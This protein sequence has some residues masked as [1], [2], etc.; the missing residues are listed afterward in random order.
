[1]LTCFQLVY[2]CFDFLTANETQL[3]NSSHKPEFKSP[4]EERLIRKMAKMALNGYEIGIQRKIKPA[5][6]IQSM[7]EKIQDTVVTKHPLNSDSISSGES[8]RE[9]TLRRPLP[10]NFERGYN[11]MD[12]IQSIGDKIKDTIMSKHP[13]S[14]NFTNG[15]SSMPPPPPLPTS[16]I[17]TF[18]VHSTPIVTTSVNTNTKKQTDT[19]K[20]LNHNFGPESQIQLT[21]NKEKPY[22]SSG[23][24]SSDDSNKEKSDDSYTNTFQKK[25]GLEKAFLVGMNTNS[26]Q[27]YKPDKT[28]DTNY[29]NTLSKRNIFEKMEANNGSN[30]NI[31]KINKTHDFRN[32]ILSETN[33]L[34]KPSMFEKATKTE[35]GKNITN[36]EE[37][38]NKQILPNNLHDCSLY[39]FKTNGTNGNLNLNQE[40]ENNF[41]KASHIEKENRDNPDSE[42]VVRRRQKKVDRNDEGRRDSCLIARP[43]STMTSVDVADG[44][45]PICHKCDKA[46]TR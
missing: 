8:S 41:G 17:P 46:I 35:N 32:N 9:N 27:D 21:I 34:K 16:P 1:M 7:A 12:S 33:T 22:N 44:N 28:I 10:K 18:N 5:D 40:H 37:D 38:G 6:H 24:S 19:P 29:S 15:N 36:D 4:A 13:A 42:V 26:I 14:A 3:T 20:N 30:T 39:T 23:Y 25:N 2:V 45:Y 11:T 43:K 31:E